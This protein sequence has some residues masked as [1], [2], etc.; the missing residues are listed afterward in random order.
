MLSFKHLFFLLFVS[1]GFSTNLFS[2]DIITLIDGKD[3]EAQVSEINVTEI[4]YKKSENLLGPTYR[5]SRSEVFKIKYAV[6]T[7]DIITPQNTSSESGNTYNQEKDL[8]LKFKNLRFHIDRVPY[9]YSE[10]ES[11]MVEK[12]N[13]T[14]LQLFR[15]GVTMKKVSKPF[16]FGGLGVGIAGFAVGTYC[17]LLTLIN[18][19][20]DPMFQDPIVNTVIKPIIVPAY[21]L[22]ALGWASF[23][24][25]LNLKS[26]SKKTLQL[27]V[28]EYN[29]GL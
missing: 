5:I 22:S 10:V 20:E 7:V 15:T 26:N 21:L 23:T 24:Y 16:M 3:I 9:S 4:V 2:Q 28:D 12:N 13:Q 29:R 18:S 25:G 11:M 8:T 19:M 27:A 17:G 14:A 1:F 6:G